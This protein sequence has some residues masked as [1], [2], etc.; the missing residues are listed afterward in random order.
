MYRHLFLRL[1]LKTLKR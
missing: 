1:G